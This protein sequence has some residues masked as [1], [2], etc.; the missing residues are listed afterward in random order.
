MPPPT[1]FFANK[2]SHNLEL[3]SKGVPYR[4]SPVHDPF[5]HLLLSREGSAF[6]PAFVSNEVLSKPRECLDGEK[7]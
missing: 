7:T 5:V 1:R 6:I 2:F 3:A 4:V